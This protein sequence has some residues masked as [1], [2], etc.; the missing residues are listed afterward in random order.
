MECHDKKQVMNTDVFKSLAIRLAKDLN[1]HWAFEEHYDEWYQGF[2][3]RNPF[4]YTSRFPFDTNFSEV[5]SLYL[6]S[7]VLIPVLHP[8]MNP[9]ER[10]RAHILEHW[11]QM[12]QSE[13]PSKLV[14]VNN[15][16]EEEI[17]DI[18]EQN[19]LVFRP[20]SSNEIGKI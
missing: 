13:L 19:Q 12:L 2:C 10:Q 3:K 15:D 14:A 9:L 4:A 18:N 16:E 20:R 5:T 6:I 11:D 8:E 7:N 17:L 1:L